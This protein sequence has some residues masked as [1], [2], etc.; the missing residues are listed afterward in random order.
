MIEKL[1]DLCRDKKELY[2]QTHDFPDPDA[3]S[4]GYALYELLKLNG[5]SAKFVYVGKIDRISTE[6]MVTLFDIPI[7]PF[8][9][10]YKEGDYVICIDSQKNTGNVLQKGGNVFACIDH[11]PTKTQEDYDYK[12]VDLMGAC[13]TVMTREYMALG[14][15]MP[16]ALATALLYGLKMDTL[17]FSRGVKDDDITVFSYLLKRADPEKLRFLETSNLILSDLRAFGIAI[18]NI[19]V[20]SDIGLSYVPFDCPDGL[21]SAL[22]DFM[23]SI[24][25]LSIAIVFSQR[26]QGIKLSVRSILPYVDAGILTRIALEGIGSGGG[27]PSFAGGYIPLSKMQGTQDEWFDDLKMRFMNAYREVMMK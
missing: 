12:Q 13:A 17:Q 7:E 2:I 16:A 5:I 8:D 20:I 10:N 24:D 19:K 11:H 1:L 4:S 18:E 6:R 23:L 22:S 21:V 25:E 27:H 15:E 9:G 26:E 14:V 3:I